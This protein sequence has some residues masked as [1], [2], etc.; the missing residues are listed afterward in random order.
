MT[1]PADDRLTEDL[2]R[3]LR[4]LEKLRKPTPWQRGELAAIRRSA[5]RPA[6]VQRVQDLTE[7]WSTR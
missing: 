2:R 1:G 5:L 4:E 7:R 3:R 6:D